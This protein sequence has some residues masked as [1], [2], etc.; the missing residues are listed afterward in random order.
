M[1]TNV[2]I[3]SL[4]N[5]GMYSYTHTFHMP[6]LTESVNTQLILHSLGTLT[7]TNTLMYTFSTIL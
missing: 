4:T 7:Q 3:E 1:T 2:N 6:L 5:I